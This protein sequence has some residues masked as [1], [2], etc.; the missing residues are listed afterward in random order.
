MLP[1]SHRSTIVR[2]VLS[3]VDPGLDSFTQK[4][5]I[6]NSGESKMEYKGKNRIVGFLFKT[7]VCPLLHLILEVKIAQSLSDAL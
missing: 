3:T 6:N 5:K 7:M 2:I 4:S 1:T